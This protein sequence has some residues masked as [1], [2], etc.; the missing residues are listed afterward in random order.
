VLSRAHNRGRRDPAITSALLLAA[1]ALA[2]L[3]AARA[4]LG[5][6]YAG[7][8]H[9]LCDCPATPIRALASGHLHEFFA[10]Q[11]VMG[12]FSLLIR[13][14]FAA[15]GLHLGSG[16]EREL[17]RLG[18]FPCLLAAGFL[19][20]YLF[21]RMRDLRRPLA[22]CAIAAVLVAVSPLTDRA[23]GYG[24]PEEI[25]AAALAVGAVLAASRRRPL[26][27]GAL[28]GAAFATK[29]WALLAA[30]PVLIAVPREQRIRAALAAAGAAALLIVP[31][32]AGDLHRF[33]HA[34][35]GAGVIGAGV[36]PTNIWFAFGRDV[37]VLITAN[38]WTSPPRV[39]PGALAA[40]SHP[41]ILAIGFA[42]AL[43][44]W[45]AR[46]DA[47][48]EDALALLALIFLVRC[49]LDPM[50][51]S[52]YHLPVLMSLA[53]WEGLR[54]ERGPVLTVATTLLIALTMALAGGGLAGVQL[55]RFYLVW[56]LP[57]AGVLGLL[58]FRPPRRIIALEGRSRE[59][60][61]RWAD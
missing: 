6:D 18:A 7:P 5:V 48:P 41:L 53:A 56:A 59:E 17:Y 42:L 38:G 57:L 32:A 22:A 12:S 46:R 16:S 45:R 39:L 34:N 43:A 24:H 10:S 19:A 36:M 50:T 33:M 9:T 58:A 15:L 40:A 52:Y 13:A 25:L 3:L 51:N 27:A 11:P 49:L 4:P 37:P 47:H 60:V 35:H 30:L 29:Q 61:L 28:L 31:I 54:R 20:A 23:L 44:W 8:P 2:A 55:N 14:P 1:A 21:E 26:A